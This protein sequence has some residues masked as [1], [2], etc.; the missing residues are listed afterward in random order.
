M[1]FSIMLHNRCFSCLVWLSLIPQIRKRRKKDEFLFFFSFSPLRLTELL[2][3]SG[4]VSLAFLRIA[5]MTPL[6]CMCLILEQGK[7]E[8]NPRYSKARWLFSCKLWCVK[9]LLQRF[10]LSIFLALSHFS[11]SLQRCICL[12][13]KLMKYRDVSDEWRLF[14]GWLI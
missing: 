3:M 9:I 1:T 2:R 5:Q 10:S 7:E 14:C 6:K 13:L 4:L 12:N 8:K 11:F